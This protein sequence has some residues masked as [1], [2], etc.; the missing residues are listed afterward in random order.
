MSILD[1]ILSLPLIY[2]LYTG[3]SKGLIRQLTGLIGGVVSILFGIKLSSYLRIY[4][5]ENDLVNP[6]WSAIVG[7]VVTIL[8]ILLALRI[9]GAIVRKTTQFIGLGF[10][11]ELAGAILGVIKFA[12]ITMVILLFFVKINNTLEI[13]PKQTFA[14]S[15]LYPYYI[16]GFNYL[17]DM[18][19]MKDNIDLTL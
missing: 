18:W 4:L 5:V 1:I 17:Y 14:Q 12:L 19:S 15:M 11:E 10:I 6:E 16:E 13:T 3:Y 9:A 8:G 7:F 2:G